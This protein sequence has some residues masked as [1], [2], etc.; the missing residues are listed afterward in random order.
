MNRIAENTCDDMKTH[1]QCDQMIEI[2]SRNN[3]KLRVIESQ[4]PTSLQVTL[5]SSNTVTHLI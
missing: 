1:I 4:N 5:L 3:N 2:I